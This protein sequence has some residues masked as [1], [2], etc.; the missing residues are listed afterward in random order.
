MSWDRKSTGSCVVTSVGPAWQ[1]PVPVRPFWQM[2][3]FLTV[4][5][6][7]L[8]GQARPFDGDGRVATN[9]ANEEL[10]AW[11]DELVTRCFA[12]TN[13]T[14]AAGFLVMLAG[15]DFKNIGV[16]TQVRTVRFADKRD[17]DVRLP[18]SDER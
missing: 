18:L 1:A 13:K 3:A 11:T 2:P 16:Q 12:V 4:R 17:V 14:I 9:L 8:T 6:R 5:K 7:R 10:F 15:D